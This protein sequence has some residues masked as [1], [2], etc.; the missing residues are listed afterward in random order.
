[1]QQKCIY[2][3]HAS[4]RMINANYFSRLKIMRFFFTK[5]VQVFYTMGA[6]FILLALV[7]TILGTCRDFATNKL[8]M[9]SFL[10]WVV[11]V[12]SVFQLVGISVFGGKGIADYSTYTPDYSIIIAG[13]GLGFSSVSAIMFV[14]EI[15]TYSR[16]DMLKKML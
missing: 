4:E 6:G 14:I 8:G 16:F 12:S 9:P 11:L 1:M 10:F 2:I 13:I 15:L 5:T 7:A 3:F